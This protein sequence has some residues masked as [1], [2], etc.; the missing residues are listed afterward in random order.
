MVLLGNKIDVLRTDY[1]TNQIIT[2]ESTSI[3]VCVISWF[4]LSSVVLC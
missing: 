1:I 2:H 4:N 3:D